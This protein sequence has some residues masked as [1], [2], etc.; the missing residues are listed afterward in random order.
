MFSYLFRI[1]GIFILVLLLHQGWTYLQDHLF[2]GKNKRAPLVNR[3][4]EKY[5]AIVEEIQKKQQNA[6]E[7]LSGE[8]KAGM[9]NDLATFLQETEKLNKME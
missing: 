1:I 5:K 2:T 7:F 4:I 3:Q 8:E 9:Q 6:S